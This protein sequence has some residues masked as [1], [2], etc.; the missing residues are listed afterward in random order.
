[1]GSRKGTNTGP[2]S[3]AEIQEGKASEAQDIWEQL[4]LE[5]NEILA[6]DVAALNEMRA[7]IH[8]YVDVF[9]VPT[10]SIGCTDKATFRVE[11]KPG[12]QPVR[13]KVRPLNPDQR[14]SLQE[15]LKVWT[16]EGVIERTSSPWASP[17]VPVMK[18]TG[19]I[20]WAV[21]Y[22]ALNGATVSDTYPLPSI[23]ESL[24]RLSGAE[25]F[26]CL[27]A[28]SAYNVIPV[29][30]DS[31][32]KLAFISPFGCHLEQRTVEPVMLGSLA[33]V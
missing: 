32:E 7:M 29:E 1:M 5:D 30:E 11:L 12:T 28:A 2:V 9:S 23:A 3:I 21:D 24:E 27:D 6:A 26:S 13:Q 17:L 22:R 18:K 4:K 10:A 15:Q 33:D 16:D 20:R 19:D 14:K 31:R 25:I 8:E